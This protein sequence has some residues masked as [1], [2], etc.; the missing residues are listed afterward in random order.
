VAIANPV[1]VAEWSGG[2]GVPLPS[3]EAAI[4]GDGQPLPP[5]EVGEIA[6]AARRS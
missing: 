1:T 3:T 5:G 6:C 2:I 4:L